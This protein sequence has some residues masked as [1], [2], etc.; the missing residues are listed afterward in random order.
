LSKSNGGSSVCLWLPLFLVRFFGVHA[1]V[2]P[3]EAGMTFKGVSL[4]PPLTRPGASVF[5]QLEC[6]D[7]NVDAEQELPAAMKAVK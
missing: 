2:R 1:A 3:F 6:G 5:F 4:K 7:G